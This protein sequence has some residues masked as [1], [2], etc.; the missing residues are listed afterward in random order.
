MPNESLYKIIFHNQ[1][2][3]YEIYA[4]SVGSADIFGFLEVEELLFG[5]RS[6]LLVDPGEEK[7]KSEFS[8]VKRTYIPMHAIVRIDEVEKE[9]VAK[10]S[11]SKG[12]SNVSYFPTP[13]NQAQK[14]PSK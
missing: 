9:G 2:Q 4:R 1:A 10:V 14:P 13:G 11:D 6:Q 12:Q 5:E 7:L 3:V 8:G